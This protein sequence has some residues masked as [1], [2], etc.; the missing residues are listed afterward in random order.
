MLNAV[1]R[2]PYHPKEGQ[3]V[4]LGSLV[5][6]SSLHTFELIQIIILFQINNKMGPAT[7]D[8][9]LSIYQQI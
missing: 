5:Y 1:T 6:W 4:A 9:G 7:K 2:G 3:Q 8:R